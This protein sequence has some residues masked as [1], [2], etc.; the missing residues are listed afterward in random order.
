MFFAFLF[1]M[2]AHHNYQ[3]WNGLGKDAFLQHQAERFDRYMANPS[4]GI[5][6]VDVVMIV[7]I[8]GL[9]ELLAAL[10]NKVFSKIAK[11]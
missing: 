3:K 1:A 7:I 2:Y 5:L 8:F 11:P 6:I 10:L 4:T 9:Y